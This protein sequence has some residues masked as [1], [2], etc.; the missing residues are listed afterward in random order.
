M[1]LDDTG[2]RTIIGV[3]SGAEPSSFLPVHGPDLRSADCVYVEGYTRYPAGTAAGA[4][5]GS[6][7]DPSPRT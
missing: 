3:D 2:E 5:V 6:S 1:L 7:R 4:R